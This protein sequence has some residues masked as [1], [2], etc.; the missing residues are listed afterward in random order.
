M[1]LLTQAARLLALNAKAYEAIRENARAGMTETDVQ[2]LIDRVYN[3]SGIPGLRFTGDLLTGERCGEIGGAAKGRTIR[4]GDLLIADLLAEADGAACDTTR[5]FFFGAPGEK[6]HKAYETICRT[7]KK[8][9]SFLRPG[10]RAEEAYAFVSGEL[11]RENYPRLPHHAGHGVGKSWYEPPYFEQGKT[12]ALETGMM[13]A[14]EPG[15]YQANEFGMRVED[16]F[17]ILDYG[18]VDLFDYPLELEHFIIE[19]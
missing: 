1:G 5:T 7:L 10:L 19:R 14:L 8:G 12:E 4:E 15:I 17:L 13:V 2:R 18:A 6:Y 16:N 9:G 11:E 3:S